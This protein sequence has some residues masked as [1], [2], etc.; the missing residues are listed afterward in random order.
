MSLTGRL[1]G[2]ELMMGQLFVDL[3]EDNQDPQDWLRRNVEHSSDLI[4]RRIADGSMT[5]EQGI[6]ALESVKTVMQTASFHFETH[7]SGEAIS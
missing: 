1:A 5:E 6:A 7:G 2:I 3:L 4:S